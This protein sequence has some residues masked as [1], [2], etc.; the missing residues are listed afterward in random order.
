MKSCEGPPPVTR[1][2]AE[3]VA[4]DL[5]DLVSLLMSVAKSGEDPKKVLAFL[6]RV[7]ADPAGMKRKI[8]DE[9]LS[10]G[11]S[12]EQFLAERHALAG[13]RAAPRRFLDEIKKELPHGQPGRPPVAVTDEQLIE[14]AHRFS[15]DMPGASAT[16]STPYEA[17]DC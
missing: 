9:I 6:Q 14:A 7:I 3:Q 15:S 1:A 8:V 12:R 4:Q 10:R 17:A 2:E 16:A 13:M 11:I 5:I